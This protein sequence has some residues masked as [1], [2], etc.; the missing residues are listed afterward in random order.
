M[1][2]C[3]LAYFCLRISLL[4]R[5][6]SGLKWKATL[7]KRE[8]HYPSKREV[9]IITYSL[10]VTLGKLFKSSQQSNL[11]KEKKC[12]LRSLE[13]NKILGTQEWNL[14]PSS[15]AKFVLRIWSTAF[16]ESFSL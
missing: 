11:Q 16:S 9:P 14:A 4:P 6:P 7:K 8:G 5:K 10:G 2:S 12:Q 1:A 3:L 13:C 15:L